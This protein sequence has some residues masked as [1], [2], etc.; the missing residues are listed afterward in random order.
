MR[1]ITISTLA[2]VLLVLGAGAAQA[3]VNVE[4]PWVRATVPGQSGTGAF[5]TLRSA[6]DA[7]LVGAESPAARAT[8]VHE[9]AHVDGVMRMREIERLPLP[10]GQ[11]VELRPG[12]HHLMLMDLADQARPGDSL[13]LTLVIERADGSRERVDV[14]AP[15]RPIGPGAGH[16]SGGHGH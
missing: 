11:T 4:E 8:E 12:G 3:Q 5:M 14:S 6:Q 10:A 13:P 2:G 9:M 7:A 1:K 16:A 15:V